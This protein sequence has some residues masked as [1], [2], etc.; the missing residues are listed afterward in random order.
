ME[1][2]IDDFLDMSFS[3]F[4]KFDPEDIDESLKDIDLEQYVTMNVI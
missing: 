3:V 4:M 1:A 2:R